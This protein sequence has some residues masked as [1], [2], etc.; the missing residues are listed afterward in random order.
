MGAIK[1]LFLK[2]N[3]NLEQNS[4]IISI[5]TKRPKKFL[6]QTQS[7]AWRE[8]KQRKTLKRKWKKIENNKN[9]EKKNKL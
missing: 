2:V 8:E 1:L 7:K 6:D 3:K 4:Q 9:Y 5:R